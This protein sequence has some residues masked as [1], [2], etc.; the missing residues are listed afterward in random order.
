VVALVLLRGG[1]RTGGMQQQQR[2]YEQPGKPSRAHRH[3]PD[4]VV[5]KTSTTS[6]HLIITSS[7]GSGNPFQDAAYCDKKL[8]RM[9]TDNGVNKIILKSLNQSSTILRLNDYT[10]GLKIDH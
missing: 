5:N 6:V 8:A 9:K 1:R 4:S 10:F 7:P 3:T 2:R